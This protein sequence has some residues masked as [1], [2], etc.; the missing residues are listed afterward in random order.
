M[1]RRFLENLA[2]GKPVTANETLSANGVTYDAALLTDGDSEY[3]AGTNRNAITTVSTKVTRETNRAMC[4]ARA[5]NAVGS[6]AIATDP[7]RGTAPI[8]VSQG[9]SM[10]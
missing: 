2:K 1:R 3:F 4:R 8:V 7:T 9:K 5:L 10:M 6:A